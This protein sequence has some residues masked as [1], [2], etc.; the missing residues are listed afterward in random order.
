MILVLKGRRPVEISQGVII[1]GKMSWHPVHEHPNIMLVAGL[2][3][4]LKILR[5]SIGML[6]SKITHE[7]ISPAHSQWVCHEGQKLHMGVVHLLQIGDQFLLQLPKRVGSPVFSKLPGRRVYLIDI[8]RTLL[9]SKPLAPS[10][11]GTILP[12]PLSLQT[13]NRARPRPGFQIARKGIHLL[14]DLSSLSLHQVL[15]DL[16]LPGKIGRNLPDSDMV[17]DHINRILEPAGKVS[18]QL[19]LL[20]V[21]SPDAKNERP[22]PT[23]ILM[24]PQVVLQVKILTQP[25]CVHFLFQTHTIT[26]LLEYDYAI[27]KS[28]ISLT[29]V[30]LKII[31]LYLH[32]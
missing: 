10:H 14:N 15:I 18:D 3:K 32:Y 20:G 30:Y 6:Q 23:F 26:S 9:K 5:A 29:F 2:D 4:I 12:F 13:D 16:P 22:L 1:L 21:R 24:K 17:P 31:N 25:E 7:L 28:I 19:N 11:P 27:V 8:D